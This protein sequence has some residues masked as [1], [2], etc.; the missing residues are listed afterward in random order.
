MLQVLRESGAFDERSMLCV[1]SQF[2]AAFETF[3]MKLTDFGMSEV[4]DSVQAAHLR[5]LNV[6]QHFIVHQSYGMLP[7]RNFASS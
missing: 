4:I 7:A 2:K 5:Y 6:S 1:S 3:R